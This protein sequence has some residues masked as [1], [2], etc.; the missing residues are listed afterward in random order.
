L[1]KTLD[2]LFNQFFEGL[3]RFY[4]G[5]L[6]WILKNWLTKL[7]TILTAIVILV[8]S[9]ALIPMTGIELIPAQGQ[10]AV[11][12]SVELPVGTRLEVTKDIM[13]QLE[14]AVKK[15]LDGLYENLIVRAG[16]RTFFGLGAVRTN[17]GRL[18][19]TLPPAG[20]RKITSREVQN[21]LRPYF[22]N[23][24]SAVFSFSQGGGGQGP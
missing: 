9:F 11:N 5:V 10:D 17:T 22:N 21:Q 12:I 16:G 24:P 3:N 8:L 6:R 15:E 14:E 23:Y 7:T 4:E 1:A 2:D 18:T 13:L 20:V 19:V